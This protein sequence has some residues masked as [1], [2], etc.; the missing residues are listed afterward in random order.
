MNFPFKSNFLPWYPHTKFL[1]FPG[2][3]ITI[4]PLCVQTLEKHLISSFSFLTK[5]NGSLRK[6]S[7][8]INGY[9]LFESG[10]KLFSSP[11]KCQHF[12]K[13]LFLTFKNV[14]EDL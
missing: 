3:L 12:K 1:Y 8:K 14:S 9:A 10:I 7:N 2:S 13:I 6:L 11:I 4:F 5:T